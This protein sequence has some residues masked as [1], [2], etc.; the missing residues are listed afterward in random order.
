MHHFHTTL[1]RN[2]VVVL[3]NVLPV[4]KKAFHVERF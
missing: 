1:T 4:I 3:M 2:W